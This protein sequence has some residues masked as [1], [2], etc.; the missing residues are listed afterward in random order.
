MNNTDT[1]YD[2]STGIAYYFQAHGIIGN[3]LGKVRKYS[4]NTSTYGYSYYPHI[5]K[6]CE[7]LQ[8]YRE[9]SFIYF[10]DQQLQNVSDYSFGTDIL[11]VYSHPR[12]WGIPFPELTAIKHNME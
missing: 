2:T 4:P 5:I 1:Y 12:K 8:Y 10:F 7:E 3:I 9:P 11:H 6:H